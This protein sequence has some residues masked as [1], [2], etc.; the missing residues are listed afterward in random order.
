MEC[1]V[2]HCERKAVA[3]G[4]CTNHYRAAKLYGD[5]LAVKQRQ[6]HGKTVRERF[7][8]YT[9]RADGCWLWVGFRDLNGYG[10]LNVDGVPVIASRLSYQ[11]HY[12]E[13]PDGKHVCHKCDNPPCV[14]PDHLFLGTPKDN[15]ADMIN[16][17]R[18]RRRGLPGVSHHAARLTDEIVRFVRCSDMTDAEAARKFDVSRA[19]IHAV[20]HR[21]TWTH[22]S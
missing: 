5:P 17:G 18:D 2:S 19:T 1:S 3:K 22:L 10:R 20:R 4:F 7:D 13:I 9:K 6:H 14:N 12:G 11:L 21:K 15:T 8:L 16:K